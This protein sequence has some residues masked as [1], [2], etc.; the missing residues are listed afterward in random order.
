MVN[1]EAFYTTPDGEISF[2]PN[3]RDGPEAFDALFRSKD[4]VY[5]PDGTLRD[6]TEDRT[7]DTMRC[8]DTMSG[9][10]HGHALKRSGITP[11]RFH[12]ALL[13]L[14]VK[15]QERELSEAYRGQR[16]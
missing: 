1:P 10:I 13:Q 9:G 3:E 8:L 6:L 2:I 5:L 4:H 7:E 16:S 15:L 14:R 11:E 12:I